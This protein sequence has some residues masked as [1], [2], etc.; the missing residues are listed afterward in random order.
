[1]K[2]VVSI[3]MA[4][5]RRFDCG[6]VCDDD[7]AAWRR[8]ANVCGVVCVT[9]AIRRDGDGEWYGQHLVLG[10]PVDV[11]NLRQCPDDDC[12]T[13]IVCYSHSFDGVCDD[14]YVV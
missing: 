6:G 14:G 7:G 5:R 1:M 9:W 11:Q 2:S 12:V 8:R 13:E 4:M 10:G 3:E